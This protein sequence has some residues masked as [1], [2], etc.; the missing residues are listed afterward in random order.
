MDKAT[1]KHI[2][3]EE[4]YAIATKAIKDCTKVNLDQKKTDKK[5]DD[6]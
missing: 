4:F 3:L 1:P 2:T 5:K 6:L